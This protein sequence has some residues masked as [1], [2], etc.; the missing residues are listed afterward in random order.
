MPSPVKLETIPV[1]RIHRDP[2]QVRKSF[3]DESLE[4]L[5]R[6]IQEVGLIQPVLVQPMSDGKGYLLVSGERRLRATVATGATE[7]QAVVADLETANKTQVQLIENLQREDLNP[8][9]RAVAIQRW[10]QHERLN[11]VAAGEQLG[12]PRTTL[13]DWLDVLEVDRRYQL[14]VID[15]FQG[16]DSPLTVSHVAEARGLA[17]KLG[18]PN[19]QNILLDAV[20]EYK[21]SKA[22]T[23]HVAQIV[24]SRANVSILDAI[25]EVRPELVD[26]DAKNASDGTETPS[27]TAR[28]L[29]F[30]LDRLRVGV[31]QMVL[32][33]YENLDEIDQTRVLDELRRMRAILEDAIHRVASVKA[34][35]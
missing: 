29:L 15:N 1:D 26:E 6:S 35:S 32:G 28:R 34:A 10:M 12:V 5:A 17:A 24:R 21:L 31:A 20:L 23:R 33:T 19:I 3:I 22:E 14:A 27:Q 16:G 2:D 11:K 8:V 25:R 9:E 4:G 18:S 7:I 13:T 30:T